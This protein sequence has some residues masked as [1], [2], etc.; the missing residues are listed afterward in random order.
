LEDT[1]I[2]S[3]SNGIYSLPA[4]YLAVTGEVIQASQHNPPLEDLGSSMSQRLM[5]SGAAPMTGPLKAVDG[6]TGSPAVQF[7][8]AASTGF[9]KS[10]NGIGVSIGGTKVAEF[11]P[12]GIASGA[13]WI[14]ELI[15]F[16]GR[17]A[18]AL[19][20]LPFGQTLSRTTYPDLWEFAQAEIAGGNIFYNNGDGA[21][22]FG[23]G[24]MRGRVVAA[25][26]NM[27]GTPAGVLTGVTFTTG[28]GTVEGSRGGA[29]T[30]TL[31]AA[32][33]PAISSNV[34][35]NVSGSISGSTDSVMKPGAS[36]LGVTGSSGFQTNLGGAA[37]V[38]GSFSGSGSG[39]ANSNN[40]GGG[41]HNN[42]QPTMICNY[43]LFAGA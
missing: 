3:D 10:A 21:T 8:N 23:I 42:T 39:V 25:K 29:S 18:P 5:R 2:P 15:P 22:T 13:R 7:S 35:V 26:D 38:S 19:T 12:G 32:Q 14:G 37:T 31:I 43:L 9:Y 11:G 28:N 24:D 27:G 4:G 34:S 17:F 6:S 41:A 30:H 33:L 20:V 36:G 40:T 1:T 16:S